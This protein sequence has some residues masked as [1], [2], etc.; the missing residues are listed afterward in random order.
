[1][2]RKGLGSLADSRLWRMLPVARGIGRLV[3]VPS[4]SP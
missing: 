4:G 3:T 2:S 1:M